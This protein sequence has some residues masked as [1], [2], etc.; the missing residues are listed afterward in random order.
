MAFQRAT[1]LALALAVLASGLALF[2]HTAAAGGTGF[3][4]LAD[5]TSD[6]T[7]GSQDAEI[8]RIG[9][10]S[11]ASRIYFWVKV[12][13]SSSSY[14]PTAAANHVT[15]LTF[16]VNLID[17]F[18]TSRWF[19]N[20][21]DT[22]GAWSGA[23]FAVG[24][25]DSGSSTQPTP[26]TVTWACNE[27]K[28]SVSRTG[29]GA[30]GSQNPADGDAWTGIWVDSKDFAAATLFDSA[31]RSTPPPA[32]TGS[33]A[34]TVG[35]NG[36]TWQDAPTLSALTP[37][38]DN[39]V[40]VSW[41]A[42]ADNGA[43]AVSAY[44]VYRSVNGVLP[45]GLVAT[46]SSP[47]TTYD[48]TGL[49][50]GSTY[51][52]KVSAVNCPQ[53]P[54][55]T[56]APPAGEPSYVG[57]ES[58]RSAS[59]SIVPD[60]RPLAATGLAAGSPTAD[61]LQLTWTA[62]TDCPAASCTPAGSGGSGI[63][64]YK[65]YRGPSGGEALVDDVLASAVCTPACAYTSSGLTA[66]THYCYY[67]RAYDNYATPNLGPAS[68][69]ACGDTTSSGPTPPAAVAD[70]FNAIKDT[71]LTATTACVPA[72]TPAA[73]GG[74]YAGVVCND[75][76]TANH[77]ITAL[78]VSGPT[79]I[80]PGG[81][82][83]LDAKG[84]VT[85]QAATGYC[86]GT[87][88]SFQYQLKDIDTNT[89]LNTVTASIAVA[90]TA[91]DPF[92]LADSYSLSEDCSAAAALLCATPFAASGYP[93]CGGTAG[94]LCNDVNTLGH[95]IRAILG[96]GVLH[97]SLTLS[98]NGAFSYTPTA[99]YCGSDAFTYTLHDDTT[100]ADV[101]TVA[102]TLTLA[103]VNDLPQPTNDS[104][105]VITNAAPALLSPSVTA[106]DGDP[107]AGVAASPAAWS[108]LSITGVTLPNFGGT[109]TIVGS[110]IRYNPAVGF[111]GTETFS[112]TLSDAGGLSASAMVSITVRA[113][114]LPHAHFVAN[115]GSPVVG[116]P[117]TFIDS[118]ADPDP[119][120][121]VQTRAWDFGDG[122]ASA[123][124]SPTHVFGTIGGAK[125][126]LTVKDGFGAFSLPYCQS[127]AVLAPSGPANPPGSGPAPPTQPPAQ[128]PAE[129]PGT[130]AFHVDAGPAQRV[131]AGSAVTLHASAA[132]A[133][134]F[135]WIQTAGPH[136][137][138]QAAGTASPTF[139]AP[140]VANPYAVLFFEVTAQGAT[141]SAVGGVMVTVEAGPGPVAAVNSD[142]SAEPA[143]TVALDASMS[144]D[145]NGESLSYHW[146]QWEGPPVVIADP[147]AARTT[148]TVPD[149]PSGTK[150]RFGLE[151]SDGQASGVAVQTVTVAPSSIEVPQVPGD[152]EKAAQDTAAA[153]PGGGASV[154]QA[155]AA[156]SGAKVG[157]AV[158]IVVAVAAVIA[159]VLLVAL[160][161]RKGT[162]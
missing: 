31:G 45:F 79:H 106:T 159:V 61:S 4:I 155:A 60:F 146:T 130:Q 107:D 39:K 128:P 55:K 83:S 49:T 1:L 100:A 78:L 121:A 69:E 54:A 57:G 153:A 136:V 9:A 138:L 82:F 21:Y 109:A 96:A 115:P 50:T 85:Y 118:S 110:N 29:W 150:L 89:L 129:Q 28:Y 99:N 15:A 122:Y 143:Q 108:T 103:C 98:S 23:D 44:R 6:H 40:R 36:N 76:D 133:T 25:S 90:C 88:D 142:S 132:G 74:P 72:G 58:L 113:N 105:L 65:V 154:P 68:A 18:G 38:G 91:A 124:T 120:D 59:M 160:W 70:S 17:K 32:G 19:T 12:G 73:S 37:V 24:N 149:A 66:A 86:G 97:G 94:V 134:A 13:D 140:K 102:V 5:S 114:Q 52:Y 71:L 101:N 87:G 125:V 26:Y 14:D 119:G 30:A 48:D 92:A 81:T 93:A 56:S 53:L 11:D 148:F 47:S 162:T 22:A 135:A 20:K 123:A 152:G 104:Y 145:D 161:P 80:T 16:P 158:W 84:G 67:I 77:V 127:L 46:V 64:G 3:E 51:A 43:Q 157:L 35:Q 41:S 75:Q 111:S 137:D 95:A 139:A 116:Q 151:V 131:P 117:V 62:P 7:G 8:V 141:Q 147:N 2:A 144:K 42:A 27:V 156:D 33:G 34:W 63:Q 112:Y 10:S 126:C